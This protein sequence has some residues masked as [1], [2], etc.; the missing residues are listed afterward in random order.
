MTSP[1]YPNLKITDIRIYKL[2][3]PRKD[4]FTIATMSLDKVENVLI[5]IE[6][7]E[8]ID[9]WG[10]AS[11]FHAI[12]GETWRTNLAAA[13]DLKEILIGQNPLHIATLIDMMDYF[14][15]HNTTIKSA[16]D[17]ALYDIAA[18]AAGLPLYLFLGGEKRE[19]ET[20][21]TLSIGNVGE[22]AE[23]TRAVLDLGYRMIKVKVGIDDAEDYQRLEIIRQ[24]LGE[25]PVIRIDANQGW[26][27]IQAVRNLQR[28][29]PLDIEFVEQPCRASDLPGM[30]YISERSPIP[31]MADESIFSPVDALNLIREEAVPYFNVKLSKSGGIYNALRIAHIAE[32]GGRVCMVGC[33]SESPL[34]LTAAAHLALA[35]R[36]FR[37]FDLDSFLEHAENPI[38]GGVKIKKGRVEVPDEPGLG[39]APDPVYLKKLE[40]I[41]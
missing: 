34:G 41:R 35:S 5:K 23:K 30:K 31:V 20:D 29:A 9:G 4:V 21:F 36:V 39:A 37:F 11:P 7:S 13:Q 12:V 32:T 18:K 19:L 33:M 16:F 28:F 2:E 8:G 3:I 27:R 10:E 6:T 15:P 26:N 22:T 40:E 17:M 24:T 1:D 14:L 25:G 38:I